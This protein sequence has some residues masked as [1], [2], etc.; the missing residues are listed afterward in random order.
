M[1]IKKMK[2][3]DLLPADYNP[4]KDLKPGDIEYEKIKKSIDEFGYIEPI[5]INAKNK[6]TIIGGHQRLKILKE[7]GYDEVDCSI[8]KLDWEQEK[9]L[10]IALNKLSGDWDETKLKDILSELEDIDIDMELTGFDKTELD[11]LFEND[12]GFG[13]AGGGDG[14]GVITGSDNDSLADRFI[15]P[16]FSVFDCKQG[17]WINRKKLWKDIGIKSELGR[18]AECLQTNIDEKYGRKQQTGTSIFDP[19]LC[20]IIY[21]WFNIPGG[22]IL[23][24]FSGGS[25]RGIVAGKLGYKYFGIDLSEEQIEANR[26]NL[27]EI[28][29][30]KFITKNIEWKIDDSLNM[31]NYTKDN[32]F[33]LVFSCPPYFDLEKYSDKT[34]DLSNMSYDKF[35]DAYS[36]IIEKSCS[37]LKNDRFAVFVVSD[38]RDKKGCYRNF[39]ATT[40]ELF[41]QHGLSLY[42]DVV[43]IDMLGTAMIR[44]PKVFT[45]ARK[46][47]KVHQNILIFYKGDVKSISKLHKDIDIS[48][49]N[50]GE[51]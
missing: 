50:E 24:P 42:N 35:L 3:D 9:T 12:G 26:E 19:V 18:D 17:Y 40:K 46:L 15:I 36:E 23:D 37:K 39:V 25:V 11:E 29:P 44:A 48:D 13:S 28:D 14:G 22:Y 16:P 41:I 45:A 4:R 34:N 47:V 1:I 8:V 2:I 38:I 7:L 10:N 6:N 30:D 33:D 49:L 32:S 20:E 27:A 5:I 43:L 51:K 21:T 31:D